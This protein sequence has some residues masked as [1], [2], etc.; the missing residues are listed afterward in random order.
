[1]VSLDFFSSG[2]NNPNIVTSPIVVAS[3]STNYQSVFDNNVKNKLLLAPVT[4]NLVTMAASDFTISNFVTTEDSYLKI[5]GDTREIAGYTFI[6]GKNPKGTAG[7]LSGSGTVTLSSSGNDITIARSGLSPTLSSLVNGDKLWIGNTSGTKAE[8]TV[9]SVLGTTITLTA[10]APTI[11][12]T[13][14][15]VSII[16]NVNDGSNSWYLHTQGKIIFQGIN[17]QGLINTSEYDISNINDYFTRGD[18]RF[19]NCMFSTNQDFWKANYTFLFCHSAA[20][21]FFYEARCTFKSTTWSAQSE[22]Y[23]C[24]S[25]SFFCYWVYITGVYSRNSS[26]GKDTTFT[27]FW[28]MCDNGPTFYGAVWASEGDTFERKLG[29]V[30]GVGVTGAYGSKISLLFPTVQYFTTGVYANYGSDVAVIAPSYTG[31][32]ANTSPATLNTFGNNGSLVRG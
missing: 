18:I 17:F 16:P 22:F 20:G 23:R 29:S 25:D 14:A 26:Y 21:L 5:V 28:V 4:L 7:G 31:N 15:F 11:N 8:Y 1:M 24:E 13:G 19:V 3:N 2:G 12:D 9:F 32:T 27:C 6:H 30:S 10:A